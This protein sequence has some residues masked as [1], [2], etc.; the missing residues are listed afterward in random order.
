M[1]SLFIGISGMA[2]QLS[3]SRRSA[4]ESSSKLFEQFDADE[5]NFLSKTI[6]VDETRAYYFESNI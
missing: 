3:V 4:T 2:L 5:E 6:I 1:M